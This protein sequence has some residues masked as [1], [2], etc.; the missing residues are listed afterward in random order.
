MVVGNLQVWGDK[1]EIGPPEVVS[2][3]DFDMTRYPV[4]YIVEGSVK[5]VGLWNSMMEIDLT[6]S[7]LMT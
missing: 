3:K 1:R 5:R 2:S 6:S 7:F 4:G